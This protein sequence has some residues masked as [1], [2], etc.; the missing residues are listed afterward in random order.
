[1]FSSRTLK[2]GLAL[3]VVTIIAAVGYA[4]AAANTVPD[5]KAGDGQG[6]VSGYTI[7]AVVYNLNAA[8]PS[9]LDSVGFDT[10]AAAA[11]VQVQL[12]ATTGSWYSCALDTGTTWTCNTTGL[13]VSTIDQLRVVASSN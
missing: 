7:T 4:F 2:I 13:D 9:T 8:D 1:M 6:T 3:M 12:V 5:T 10:G 11:Q